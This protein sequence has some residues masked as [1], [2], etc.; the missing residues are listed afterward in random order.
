MLL[1][2]EA[3]NEAAV[4]TASAITMVEIGLIVFMFIFLG[5]VLWAIFRKRSAFDAAKRIP[6]EE[7]VVTPMK[8]DASKRAK[9]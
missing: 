4:S 6:L 2:T 1:A 5:V 8:E 3:G 9:P 7:G